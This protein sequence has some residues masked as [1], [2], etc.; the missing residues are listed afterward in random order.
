MNTNVNIWSGRYLT[1]SPKELVTDS[2]RT[3]ALELTIEDAK[4]WSIQGVSSVYKAY[5][6]SSH[7]K[8]VEITADLTIPLGMVGA[9][10]G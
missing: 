7:G 10:L 6:A 1:C 5:V 4:S 8:G 3:P 2:L 9:S